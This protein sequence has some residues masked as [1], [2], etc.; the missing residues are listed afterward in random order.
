MNGP[1]RLFADFVHPRCSPKNFTHY[2]RE[3]HL[4]VIFLPPAKLNGN[5]E[6]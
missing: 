5:G 4:K 2:I 6:G 3:V 1:V